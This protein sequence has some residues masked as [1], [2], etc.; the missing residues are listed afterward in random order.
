MIGLLV[1]GYTAKRAGA[2]ARVS[3]SQISRWRRD[4]KF[5][6]ALEAAVERQRGRIES[7]LAKAA[8]LGIRTLTTEMT[9]ADASKDRIS[10]AATVVNAHVRAVGNRVKPKVDPNAGPLIVFPPGSSIA[11][12]ARPAPDSQAAPAVVDVTS[13]PTGAPSLPAL[14]LPV[15]AIPDSAPAG[16]AADDVAPDPQTTEQPQMTFRGAPVVEDKDR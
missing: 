6:A 2:I 8:D 10:A 14:S 9:S 11:L 4:P 7:R 5:M 16:A 13:P 12:V 1:S 15:P 3:A